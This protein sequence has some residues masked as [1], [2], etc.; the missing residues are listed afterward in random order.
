MPEQEVDPEKLLSQMPREEYEFFAEEGYRYIMTIIPKEDYLKKGM[1]LELSGEYFRIQTNGE[2]VLA[3]M[4][5]VSVED[6][7]AMI[8]SALAK[9][10]VELSF[11]TMFSDSVPEKIK[12]DG[13]PL[14]EEEAKKEIKRE[15]R[16]VHNTG[17]FLREL[18]KRRGAELDA[19]NKPTNVFDQLYDERGK[20]VPSG[21]S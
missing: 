1:I 2:D 9:I 10:G 19:T 15:L 20:S 8:L 21:D 7:R 17:I 5:S 18:I 16:I 11:I 13:S 4:D 12:D 14:T 3:L 6:L